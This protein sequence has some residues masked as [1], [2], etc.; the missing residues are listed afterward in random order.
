MHM[1]LVEIKEKIEPSYCF[2]IVGAN[3]NNHKL[4]STIGH[5][6]KLYSYVKSWS[7]SSQLKFLLLRLLSQYFAAEFFF[8]F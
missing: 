1:C 3:I 8:F 2:M 6:T 7:N 4:T 5:E